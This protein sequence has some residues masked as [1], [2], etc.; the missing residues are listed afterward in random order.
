MLIQYYLQLPK[1][2]MTPKF[3][4]WWMDKQIMLY[5]YNGIL[6]SVEKEENSDTGYNMDA[7][8]RHYAKSSKPD[9]E[10]QVLYDSTSMRYLE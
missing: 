7:S 6:F 9:T 8:W 2:E 1:G 5:P 4:N 10:E 3:I